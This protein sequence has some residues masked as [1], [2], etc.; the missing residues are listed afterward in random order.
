MGQRVLE[1][2][3]DAFRAQFGDD[4]IRSLHRNLRP[5]PLQEIATRRDV[6]ISFVRKKR[7]ELMKV[8]LMLHWST[9][10]PPLEDHEVG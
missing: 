9:L 5:S 8:G 10:P 4:W 1:D 6:T 3:R 2:L 7:A